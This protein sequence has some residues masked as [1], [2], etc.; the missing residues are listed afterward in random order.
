VTPYVV[1][2]VVQKLDCRPIQGNCRDFGENVLAKVLVYQ[3]GTAQ[4]RAVLAVKCL[5]EASL[6]VIKSVPDWCESEN[7]VRYY[8]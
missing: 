8:I 1:H 5:G 6:V 3:P 7:W 4:L 2:F